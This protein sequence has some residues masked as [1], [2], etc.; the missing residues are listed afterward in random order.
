VE[1][2]LGGTRPNCTPGDKIIDVLR[3]N[4]VKELRANGNAK[5]GEVT[6]KLTPETKSLVYLKG[7]IDG[8]IIDKAFPANCRT[9]FLNEEGE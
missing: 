9:R 7:T 5:M 8:G 3:G 2:R 4:S 1:L 6:E